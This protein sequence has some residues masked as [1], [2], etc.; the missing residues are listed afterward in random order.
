MTYAIE[1]R[2]V[3]KTYGEGPTAYQA[4]K[5]VDFLAEPGEFVMLSGPSG[6]GKTTLLSILGCVLTASSGTVKL[7]D[8]DISKTK[9]SALPE[10]RLS[11]VGF[12][13]QSH[14]LLASLTATENVVMLLQLRGYSHKAAVAEAHK[15]LEEV[16]LAEKVDS[17]PGDLSG[18]QRQRVAIARALAGSPPILLADEPTAALDAQNGLAITQTLKALAKDHGHTVVV[19]T[20]DNRIF[21]LADRI[22]HIED[23]LI[24]EKS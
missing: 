3:Q 12:V 18:G 24:V 16:G 21:H 1:C 19:V 17:K 11:Y 2:N 5:G 22:V 10:L 7:F 14:N 15:L 20:H 23:G 13:F 6:S 4:L 9:E 8:D